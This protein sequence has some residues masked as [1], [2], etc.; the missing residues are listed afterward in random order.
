MRMEM[1]SQNEKRY[2]FVELVSEVI[3]KLQYLK[4]IYLYTFGS[5]VADYDKYTI[6]FWSNKNI[7]FTG[8]DFLNMIKSINEPLKKLLTKLDEI[9]NDVIYEYDKNKEEKMFT[10]I[11]ENGKKDNIIAPIDFTLKE[12][13]NLY[14][15]KTG[16][17]GCYYYYNNNFILGS[18]SYCQKLYEIFDK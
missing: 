18:F 17:F 16:N 9:K 6:P 4:E 7:T 14:E 11:H 3:K 13:I 10:F 5:F 12:L 2:A 8:S 15:N 1:I